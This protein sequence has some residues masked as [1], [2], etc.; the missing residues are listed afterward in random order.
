MGIIVDIPTITMII[1]ETLFCSQ[2]NILKTFRLL[3]MPNDTKYSCH[4]AD[5]EKYN[6]TY[7][8]R[9]ELLIPC[10]TFQVK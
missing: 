10:S 1:M 9:I 5:F 8:D 7:S 2:K 4:I 3:K 6:T